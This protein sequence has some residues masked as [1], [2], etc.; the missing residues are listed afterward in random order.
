MNRNLKRIKEK[1]KLFILI[2]I[3]TSLIFSGC[4]DN[5]EKKQTEQ[6]SEIA[7][8]TNTVSSSA[9]EIP[10]SVEQNK[11]KELEDKINSM[12]I[13]ITDLQTRLDRIGLPKP[14]NKSL[15][16][17]QL[18]FKI[19]FQWGEWQVPLQYIFKES[20]VEIIDTSGEKETGSFTIDRKNNTIKISSKK[21]D[22]YGIVL[23]DNYATAIYENGW[24]AWG[25][26]YKIT[27]RYNS[28][29]QRYE[30]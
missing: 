5:S 11:I 9:T 2:G 12:Q 23:Y 16:P 10:Q 26:K 29:T 27:Q 1:F 14:S 30:I 28:E 21:Y 22:F 19:E 20:E 6:L 4:I 24:I 7:S 17:S 15:I 18:P 25:K 13:Q 8:P 3:I